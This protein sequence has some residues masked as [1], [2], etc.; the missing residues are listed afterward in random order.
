[1][2]GPNAAFSSKRRSIYILVCAVVLSPKRPAT[3]EGPT[4]SPFTTAQPRVNLRR[5]SRVFVV[6]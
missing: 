3:N 6:C 2:Y 4:N 5:L 1:M